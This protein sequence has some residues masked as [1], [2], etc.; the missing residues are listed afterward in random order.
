MICRVAGPSTLEGS[1]TQQGGIEHLGPVGRRDHDNPARRVEPVHLGQNL[2]ERL[3]VLV[4]TAAASADGAGA[5]AFDR[6]ELV[7]EDDRRRRLFGVLKQ[8]TDPRAP[9][10]TNN[11][12]DSE[13]EVDHLC[14]GGRL[15]RSPH[16][17]QRRN[18][19]PQA[20]S[21]WP[22]PWGETMRWCLA[23]AAPVPGRSRACTRQP[24]R[25]RIDEAKVE[26]TANVIDR[27]RGGS[28]ILRSASGV[29]APTHYWRSGAFGGP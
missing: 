26:L 22:A 27:V 7:D 3:L 14:Q 28:R 1:W 5:R 24:R 15:A 4:V 23:V 9:T 17:G 12:T 11:S 18:D 8:I 10:P 6:V 19:H 13:A 21:A 16:R 2:V 20:L 29:R 25:V